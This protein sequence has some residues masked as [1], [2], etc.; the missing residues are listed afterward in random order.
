MCVQSPS[1]ALAACCSSN[2]A[3]SKPFLSAQQ[4]V[5][6]YPPGRK[7]AHQQGGGR[8]DLIGPFPSLNFL[9]SHRINISH[10][11]GEHTRWL[12]S[13]ACGGRVALW[14]HFV[15]QM[16]TESQ[17]S[18]EDLEVSESESSDL[19]RAGALEISQSNPTAEGG[20]PRA[21][22][23]GSGPGRFWI[24]PDTANRAYPR[25]VKQQRACISLVFSFSEL[26]GTQASPT[27]PVPQPG[28]AQEPHFCAIRV[29][30]LLWALKAAPVQDGKAL[31]LLLQKAGWQEHRQQTFG[32][33]LLW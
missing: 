33:S 2:S 18:S 25:K 32:P 26:W 4:P 6:K 15:L 19:W 9:L 3:L 20:S 7:A 28:A 23:T 27:I 5:N 16:F 8:D 21:G 13:P 14:R 17:N 11:V 31:H 10:V 30:V 24:P 22:C 1:P 12:C 29:L